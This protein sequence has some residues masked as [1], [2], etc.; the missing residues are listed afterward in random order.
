M[1]SVTDKKIIL[2][3]SPFVREEIS[4]I[5]HRKFPTSSSLLPKRFSPLVLGFND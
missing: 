1:W 3:H 4:G 2:T 5:S